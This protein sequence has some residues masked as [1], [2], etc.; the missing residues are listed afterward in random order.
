MSPAMRESFIRGVIVGVVVFAMVAIVCVLAVPIVL[1][2]RC[3]KGD[4]PGGLLVFLFVAVCF[5]CG[6]L[7]VHR[8]LSC[9]RTHKEI[10]A[11]HRRR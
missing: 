8:A 2:F 9:W 6:W 1:G 7:G 3:E 10:V 5:G 4:E 11:K